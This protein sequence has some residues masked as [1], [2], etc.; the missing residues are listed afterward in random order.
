MFAEHSRAV[1]GAQNIHC[2]I[3][4]SG[5]CLMFLRGG[6]FFCS[7]IVKAHVRKTL[8]LRKTTVFF[9]VDHH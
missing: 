9:S 4:R 2:D 7:L 8:S 3:C 1:I 6:A 5:W